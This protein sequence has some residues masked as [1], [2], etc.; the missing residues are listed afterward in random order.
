[1]VDFEKVKERVPVAAFFETI[2][3]LKAKP[4]NSGVR[5]SGCPSCGESDDP[6]SIRVNVRGNKWKCFVCDEGGDVIDAA[7]HFFARNKAEAAKQLLDEFG[8]P[9]AIEKWK[10]KAPVA[11]SKELT[12]DPAVTHQV[13]VRLLE[14]GKNAPLDRKVFEYLRLRNISEDA[15]N[16]ARKQNMI[17]SLPSSP[18]LAK[19]YLL[20]VVG[21]EL[22]EEAG[23]WRPGTKA[24]GMAYRPL[25]FVTAGGRS[26]EFRLIRPK[27]NDREVKL[28]SYGPMSPFFFA[29]D[30]QD[31]FV[32]TEGMT[33]LLSVLTLRRKRNASVIG[34]A[35]CNRF[36]PKWFSKMG[37]KDILLALDADGPGQRAIYKPEG[38]F[39]TLKEYQAKV[40]VFSF[41]EKFISE[42]SEKNRDMNGYLCWRAASAQ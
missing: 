42:T 35:G 29:G 20:K 25:G 40:S 24:P 39:N 4:Q 27:Q 11:L 5:F 14:A 34:L 37:G 3:G 26:I 2:M 18:S 41:P 10:A 17:V 22:L 32:V 21:R 38:L 16:A 23:M 33:D 30:T 9:E 19:N 6:A 7:E 8:I 15:I 36:V 12:I 1:M 28:I 31:E 13:I